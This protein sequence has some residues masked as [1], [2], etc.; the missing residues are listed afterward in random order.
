LINEA[1]RLPTFRPGSAAGERSPLDV[2]LLSY[3]D[4]GGGAGRAAYRLLQGLREQGVRVQM[5]ALDPV[6]G[7]PA[8]RGPKSALGKFTGLMRSAVDRLPLRLVMRGPRPMFSLAWLPGRLAHRVRRRGPQAVHLH[9]LPGGMLRIES[10]ARLG[11]PLIWTMHDMWPFTGGC[12]Y[13]EGCGRHVDACGRCPVLRSSRQRDLSRWVWR[14]KSRAWR[15]VPITLVA[16]SRWLAD[17]GRTS[18]LFRDRPVRVIPNGLDLELFQPA[19]PG[20]ARRLLGLSPDR[21][22]LLFGAFDAG[23]ERRKGFG[24][25]QAALQHLAEAGWRDRL[26]LLVVGALAP[27]EPLDLGLPARYLG[28]LRDELSMVLA[29]AAADAVVVPSIQDNLPNSAIEAM[30]CGRPCIGFAVGGLPEIVEDG[31]SGRLARTLE[32]A[33]LAQAIAWVLGDEP[34]RLALGWQARRKAEEAF[35]LRRSARC[36]TELYREVIAGDRP[37]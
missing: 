2:L 8:V 18:S 23:G 5:E 26:E 10:L 28:L 4:S 25:L 11:H 36:Y 6:T 3:S 33:D 32:P 34:R 31:V 37:S 16:P 17:R 19:D 22:Y 14:R 29:L 1:G 24:L 13:D 9:W 12:H 7:D 35:D 30:A 15:D 21:T 27:A 20:L